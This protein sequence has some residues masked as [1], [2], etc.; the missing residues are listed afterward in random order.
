[1][2]EFTSVAVAAFTA[3]EEGAGGFQVASGFEED[4]F[5]WVLWRHDILL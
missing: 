3:G 4:V 5:L 1:M 2:T